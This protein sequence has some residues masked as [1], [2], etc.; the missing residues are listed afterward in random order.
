[1]LR[2]AEGGGGGP[3]SNLTRYIGRDEEDLLVLGK[4]G[5]RAGDS[6]RL[7]SGPKS[8]LENLGAGKPLR[9]AR[10]TGGPGQLTVVRET[11]GEVIREGG[12]RPPPLGEGVVRGVMRDGNTGGEKWVGAEGGRDKE[13][14]EPR[15]VGVGGERVLGDVEVG[16]SVMLDFRDAEVG[17]E[18]LPTRPE[19][20]GGKDRV[21]AG[22]VG[23]R[24]DKVEVPTDKCGDP[25]V[26]V[27]KRV[28]EAPIEGKVSSRPEV[29][30]E[31]LE[32]RTRGV[33]G[34]VPAQLGMSLG[35]RREGDIGPLV[36]L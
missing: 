28:E 30:V 19:G 16:V 32:G 21:G 5:E 12:R 8:R 9:D 35:D 6:P 1:M 36:K 13:P 18:V 20:R 24:V 23:G 15:S 7:P 34:G 3:D 11:D 10:V 27:E 2:V 26:D 14:V 31:N 25:R 22:G 17:P 29:E 33:V 4:S